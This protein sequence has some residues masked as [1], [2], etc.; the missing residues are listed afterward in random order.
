VKIEYVF[1]NPE[2]CAKIFQRGQEAC[3]KYKWS[4]E[5]IRFVRLADRLLSGT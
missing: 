4:S 1:G 5:R 3:L 2:E